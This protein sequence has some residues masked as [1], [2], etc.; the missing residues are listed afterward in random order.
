MTDATET[1]TFTIP[2]ADFCHVVP[3][4]EDTPDPLA[5]ELDSEF[6]DEDIVSVETTWP[7]TADYV[8]PEQGVAAAVLLA[9][10]DQELRM[11]EEW[12]CSDVLA[13]VHG[14]VE[15]FTAGV[16]GGATVRADI[17]VRTDVSADLDS[18][19]TERGWTRFV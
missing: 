2:Q 8:T 12:E 3:S 9:N 5:A 1:R 4:L 13:S 14:L 10:L 7:R 17:T 18:W 16:L 6:G 11:T 19:M 15:R